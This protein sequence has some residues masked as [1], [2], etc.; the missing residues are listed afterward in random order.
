[1]ATDQPLNIDLG[2]LSAG[3]HEFEYK[4]D[5]AFFEHLDQDVILGGD[6]DAKV[7]VVAHEDTFQLHLEVEGEVS[8][9]CDRCLDPVSE[10]VEAEDDLLI[11]LAAHD[12]E[13]DDCVYID[14]THP[15]FDLGWLLYEEISVSLP[16]VC[17]HQPGECNPQMEELL[18]AH[19]CTTIEDD[20][21]NN[22]E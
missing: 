1:M 7:I 4:L 14:M 12:D 15:V 21:P 22:E 3:R 19:L 11:K 10:P 8:V 2:A 20:E 18:Q 6:V 9:T 16:I 5:N 13:D 17:R